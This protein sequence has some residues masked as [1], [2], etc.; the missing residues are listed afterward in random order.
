MERKGKLIYSCQEG[1][2]FNRR[3]P[4]FPLELWNQVEVEMSMDEG[5]EMV[6]SQ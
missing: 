5:E 2:K 6:I 1:Q 4:L 3:K